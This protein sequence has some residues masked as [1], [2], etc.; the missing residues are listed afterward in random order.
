MTGGFLLQIKE[1]NQMKQ[2]NAPPKLRRVR[3]LDSI[4]LDADDR[5]YFTEEG[6]LVD[7]PVLTSV[8]IFEYTNPDGTIRRE[9]RLPEHVFAEKSLKTYRGKPVIITHSAGKIS[10]ENVDREQIGTILSDGYQD[11]NDVRAEIIIHNTDAMKSSGLKELSLGYNLDLIEEPGEWNGQPYDAV[12]TNIVINHLA[13][14]ASAR[15]GDQARLNIDGFDEPEL[16]GTRITTS[17]TGQESTE[18]HLPSGSNAGVDDRKNEGGKKPMA[19]LNIDGFDMTPEQLVEAISQYRAFHEGGSGGAAAAGD[20]AGV[21]GA[22]G[23]KPPVGAEKQEPAAAQEVPS[24]A[25]AV[26]EFP[27]AEPEKKDA[28]DLTPLISAVEQLLEALKAKDGNTDGAEGGA[29]APVSAGEG[30]PADVKQNGEGAG[31]VADCGKEDTGTDGSGDRSQSLNADSADDLF[32]QRL[33]ICRV[34]DRLGIEGLESMS[35]LDGKKAVISKVLPDMR[36]DGKDMAYVDA[37]YDI[38]VEKA[39]RRKDV[40]YQRQQ[41]ASGVPPAMRTDSIG[42]DGSMASQARLKMIEREGGNV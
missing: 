38:A 20:G 4:R 35:I 29:A 27:A 33:G 28:D 26:K 9:L 22:V 24:A 1:M 5:T 32:R 19:N 11:N 41:M 10:K 30:D 12:Q 23:K 7:H 25:P 6:Y 31:A 39:E 17:G 8:G 18:T 37:A 15:A 34:G 42:S 14:V 21:P 2:Q 13:L 16:K 36:L 40:N 3:R